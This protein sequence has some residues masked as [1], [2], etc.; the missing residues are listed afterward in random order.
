[1]TWVAAGFSTI[2][3]L[4][5]LRRIVVGWFEPSSDLAVVVVASFVVA[6]AGGPGHAGSWRASW[7][8]GPGR[9]LF[10]LLLRVALTSVV[11]ALLTPLAPY[12]TARVWTRPGLTAI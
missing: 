4:G 1:M 12:L 2:G 9:Y 3:M 7:A 5:A 6:A 11:L 10:L 8:R